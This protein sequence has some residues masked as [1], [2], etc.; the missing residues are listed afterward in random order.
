L[1]SYIITQSG[2]KIF[3]EL[4]YIP[5]LVFDFI[6]ENVSSSLGGIYSIYFKG[7]HDDII[8]LRNTALFSNLAINLYQEKGE[9]KYLDAA[10]KSM[11]FI[12]T[13]FTDVGIAGGYIEALREN[14]PVQIS[15]SL[16]SH[17]FVML[18]WIK[19]VNLNQDFAKIELLSTWYT[20]DNF[21]KKG[22]LP[23]YHST[24]ET[25][26]QPASNNIN[27]LD[28]LVMIFALSYMPIISKVEHDN[29][30]EFSDL[31]QTNITLQV[32]E[33]INTT[34]TVSFDGEE[35]DKFSVLG[36]G[37]LEIFPREYSLPKPSTN[38]DT[39]IMRVNISTGGIETDK[40]TTAFFVIND[41]GINLSIQ[42]VTI[43]SGLMIMAF[44]ILFNRV[45]KNYEGK[46]L[47]VED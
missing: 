25:T 40:L 19:M 5:E 28:N 21:F 32:P 24:L 27:T 8:T 37:E 12:Q 3:E 20:I 14:E 39:V 41:P 1:A 36:T 11:K 44:V 18:A 26:G 23:Y 35:I 43:F 46:P 15:K 34:I 22:D 9:Q 4:N 45:F 33:G 30:V 17:A 31:F 38:I 2:S 6:N 16:F 42:F 10:I 7:F 47:K 13:Y 29:S